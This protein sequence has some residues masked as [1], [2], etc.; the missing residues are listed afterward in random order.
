MARGDHVFVMSGFFGVPF[1]HHGIDIG[2]GTVVHLA[3]EGRHRLTLRAKNAN[4]RVRQITMEEFC[5]GR[6]LQ[7]VRHAEPRPTEEVVATALNC[8]GHSEYHWLENNCEHFAHWCITGQSHSRQVEM[9]HLTAEA[10]T[11]L[12]AK[13]C[14]SLG[15][16]VVAQTAVRSVTRLHPLTFVADGVEIAAIVG[17]CA[18]G[19]DAAR[20]RSI[21]R[22]SGEI[23][24]TAIG[25]FLGGPIGGAANLALHRSSQQLAAQLCH[26][27]R[28]HL[29]PAATAPNQRNSA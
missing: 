27:T 3:P 24:A 28:Q 13:G 22:I 25:C 1:Q 11:S 18:A 8:V 20:S 10:I 17:A 29:T 4:F 16:R 15:Q 14:M 19:L 26:K 12:V 2:D 9:G 23:T 6:T 5:K 21:A 7:V